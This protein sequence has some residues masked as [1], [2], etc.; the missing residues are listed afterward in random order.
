MDQIRRDE[1]Q[2]VAERYLRVGLVV[3]VVA[4]VGVFSLSDSILGPLGHAMSGAA[5]VIRTVADTTGIAL[6][7][8]A[9]LPVATDTLGHL[10]AWSVVGFAAAGVMTQP[11]HRINVLLGLLVVS[12]LFEVG[13]R[14]LSWS[15]SAELS[16]LVA[17]GVGLVVGFVAFSIAEQLPRLRGHGPGRPD[18]V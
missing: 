16:D 7:R 10:A 18:T 1:K 9:D 5:D 14:H 11:L 17:N 15:R 13:Q 6:G 4:V 12:A 3:A 8:R 2:S